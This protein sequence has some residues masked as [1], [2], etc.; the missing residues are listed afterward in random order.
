VGARSFAARLAVAFAAGSVAVTSFGACASDYASS[1]AAGSEGGACYGNGTCDDGLTCASN[2]CVRLDGAALPSE[3]GGVTTSDAAP[4]AD[5]TNDDASSSSANDATPDVRVT[6]I[7]A[8]GLDSG[9]DAGVMFVTNASF[10]VGTDFASV[11]GADGLCKQAADAPA[12]VA[13]LGGRMWKAWMS[14]GSRTALMRMTPGLK[15][16]YVRPDGQPLGAPS[17]FLNGHPLLNPP[18]VTETGTTVNGAAST[19]V[20]TGTGADGSLGLTYCQGW[21]NGL[22]TLM[23]VY[24]DCTATDGAWSNHSQSTCDVPGR[25]YCFEQ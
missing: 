25:I 12:A 2:V 17:D 3:G 6:P 19:G 1:K 5:A 4:S 20:W 15:P 16:F 14:D 11:F 23:G 21:Q 9:G 10:T 22:N 13:G 18:D 7:D 8:A 24:G